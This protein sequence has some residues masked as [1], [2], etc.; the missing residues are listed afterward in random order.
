[1]QLAMAA[2][3]ALACGQEGGEPAPQ[4]GRVTRTAR[5]RIVLL[6]TSLTAGLGV[7]PDS[8]YPAILQRRIDSLGV[9]WEVVN[10]GVSGETAAG[11]LRRAAWVFRE[12]FAALVIE[13]GA[14]DGL[15]GTEPDSVRATLQALVDLAQRRA[16]EA[17]IVVA[18]MEAPPNLGPRYT[19][20][21]RAI[22]GDL[23]HVNGLALI[24]FLLDGVGGVDSLNQADRIH[25]NAAGHRVLAETVW[26]AVEPI[27]TSP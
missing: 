9:G 25:P 20:R 1:M 21:F 24:P 2:I 18:G 12:P 4:R 26:K 10:A 8:A 11:G 27:V 15:R 13:L 3:M 17:A 14:N 19:S 22:F 6:G 5:P 23:A 7:P 16:P